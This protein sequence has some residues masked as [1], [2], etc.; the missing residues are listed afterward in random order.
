MG[1]HCHRRWDVCLGLSHVFITQLSHSW[2][3]SYASTNPT[4]RDDYYRFNEEFWLTSSAAPISNAA[5]RRHFDISSI[6]FITVPKW[7]PQNRAWATICGSFFTFHRY[8]TVIWADISVIIPNY[9]PSPHTPMDIPSY[10][11][12]ISSTVEC[13]LWGRKVIGQH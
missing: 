8:C 4:V 12:P 11:L 1:L 6:L 13:I 2:S 10:G 7:Q 9:F 5:K 3:P